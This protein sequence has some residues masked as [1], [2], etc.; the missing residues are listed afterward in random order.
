MD[1]KEVIAKKSFEL[2]RTITLK[3]SLAAQF[4]TLHFLFIIESLTT[5]QKM[6]TT[7]LL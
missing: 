1:I 7:I 3:T 5:Y 2:L 4:F 6:R